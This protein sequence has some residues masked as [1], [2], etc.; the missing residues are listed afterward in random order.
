V[1]FRLPVSRVDVV[2]REPTGTDDLFLCEATLA[3]TAVAGCVVAALGRR[4]D[5]GQLAWDCLSVYD[6]DAAMLAIRRMVIG[7]R[8]QSTVQCECREP[9]DI[10]F[11]IGQYLEHHAPR[12]L[13]SLRRAAEDGWWEVE[14]VEGSFRLPSAADVVAISVESEP[15]RELE[16]RCLRPSDAGAKARRRMER[17]MEALAPSL[18]GTLQAVCTRCEATLH[19]TFDPQSYVLEELRQRAVFVFEEVHLIAARYNW[20]EADVLALPQKRRARYAELI[21][22]AQMGG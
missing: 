10:E 17:A 4:A 15:L 7:E 2:F 18:C 1:Q 9:I 6:L 3:P 11:S 19:L 8:V 5:G 13:R 20:S 12:A 16:R 21:H 22:A 14:G